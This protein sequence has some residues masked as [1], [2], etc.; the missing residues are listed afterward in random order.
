MLKGLT[1]KEQVEVVRRFKQGNF[2]TI[3][4]T[5]VGEEGLDIGEVDLI[6]F[7]DVSK[8][9]IRLIQRMGRTGRK[10]AGKIIVL[11]TEGKQ[12]QIYNSAI[13]SKNS[14]KKA[15]LDKNRL[16]QYLSRAPRMVPKGI[17]PTC[18][19]MSLKPQTI[20]NKKVVAKGKN[21]NDNKTVK[22]IDTS[23]AIPTTSIGKHLKSISHSESNGFL[24]SSELEYWTKNFKLSNEE[25]LRVPKLKQTKENWFKSREDLLE[26]INSDQETIT[27]QFESNTELDLSEWILWQDC[28]QK[29]HF[30]SQSKTSKMF[31]DILNTIRNIDGMPDDDE[32]IS[33]DVSTSNYK[34]EVLPNVK[35]K[36]FSK[37]KSPT[38][39]I[40]THDDNFESSNLKYFKNKDLIDPQIEKN[41][42]EALEKPLDNEQQ[43]DINRT[44]TQELQHTPTHVLDVAESRVNFVEDEDSKFWERWF[45]TDEKVTKLKIKPPPSFNSMIKNIPEPHLITSV[46]V[47]AAWKRAEKEFQQEVDR[48]NKL[49]KNVEI[50]LPSVG[51]DISVEP[52]NLPTREPHKVLE[53][54]SSN[55]TLKRCL[56]A[57]EETVITSTPTANVNKRSKITNISPIAT[58]TARS[59]SARKLN[60]FR[61]IPEEEENDL[62]LDTPSN[63]GLQQS[64]FSATQLVSFVNKS[65]FRLPHHEANLSHQK[66]N[67]SDKDFSVPEIIPG[68]SQNSINLT[69]H[70][71]KVVQKM[72]FQDTDL[73]SES[74]QNAFNISYD[75]VI[76]RG[77]SVS[78][79]QKDDDY[80]RKSQQYSNFEN[81]P[82]QRSNLDKEYS[83][84][85]SHLSKS[86][87]SVND[88]CDITHVTIDDVIKCNSGSEDF[89]QR[90]CYSNFDLVLDESSLHMS[91]HYESEDVNMDLENTEFKMPDL[92]AYEIKSRTPSRPKRQGNSKS[93]KSI[94]PAAK[95]LSANDYD[96]LPPDKSGLETATCN[97]H[98]L[99]P[100]HFDA[101]VFSQLPQDIKEELLLAEGIKK[102]HEESMDL[103]NDTVQSQIIGFKQK[104]KGIKLLSSSSEDDQP[105]DPDSPLFRCGPKVLSKQHDLNYSDNVANHKGTEKPQKISKKP[106]T[107]SARKFIDMEA[108]VSESGSEGMNDSESDGVDMDA[109]E[110]SFMDDATQ[111]PENN[112]DQQAIYLRSIRSPIKGSNINRVPRKEMR[113]EEIFSQFDDM[114]DDDYDHD[115]FVVD[116]DVIEYES[117]TDPLD[118][119]DEFEEKNNIRPPKNVDKMKGKG[120]KRGRIMTKAQS[121]SSDEDQ[122]GKAIG[123]PKKLLKTPPSVKQSPNR[124][125]TKAFNSKKCFEN[126]S[127]L[128]H[129]P[130]V[131]EDKVQ[132]TDGFDATACKFSNDNHFNVSCSNLSAFTPVHNESSITAEE[133][134]KNKH[135]ILVSAS[136]VQ[137]A[138]EVVSSLRHKHG[139]HVVSSKSGID[140]GASY[141]VSPR[142]AVL[143]IS[144]Q[145][146]CNATNR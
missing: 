39:P 80:P 53:S 116:S 93:S 7:Y 48:C 86:S 122:N 36:K 45:P 27:N 56:S 145:E 65:S 78:N 127:N 124:E 72:S 134:D 2:N 8:S 71:L 68:N 144:T 132:K 6:I 136:E 89:A 138:Q 111:K 76:V 40:N 58:S 32:L 59:G 17:Y 38:K 16:V 83:N 126:K 143:R 139:I 96:L 37:M 54:N 69:A 55:C 99:I 12:E 82:M 81:K 106:N 91:E 11:L 20:F 141:M 51:L 57:R 84:Y 42:M 70:E 94:S 66:Q 110:A 67:V 62:T 88:S 44:H 47:R 23:N 21:A 105:S 103:D 140:V 3:V 34:E 104:G 52:S 19:Q 64:V 24:G 119:I 43:K 120:K 75:D 63:Q 87:K 9:P 22:N 114:Q 73:I 142:C 108:V 133:K 35:N 25:N 79:E 10:R 107:L 92:L 98:S 95:K 137:R 123:K 77:C 61:V 113:R 31:E 85:N 109:Y 74:L 130:L 4:C 117:N 131:E 50:R 115:S 97:D 13:Y 1:Q 60:K 125:S 146:F 28:R 33:P 128:V 118:F 5:C 112:I 15:L 41:N 30:V 14:I 102:R 26:K 18:H 135:S 100:D 49:Q 90:K 101:E 121:S 29:R 129:P 46:D